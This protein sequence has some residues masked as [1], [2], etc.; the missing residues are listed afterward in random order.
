MRKQLSAWSLTLSCGLSFGEKPETSAFFLKAYRSYITTS[1][2]RSST[3][4]TSTPA[5][6]LLLLLCPLPLFLST[7]LYIRIYTRFY[8]LTSW[9]IAS[10]AASILTRVASTYMLT[11]SLPTKTMTE[12]RRTFYD[13]SF[14]RSTRSLQPKSSQQTP[15]YLMRPQIQGRTPTQAG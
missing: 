13:T 3:F 7:N 15:R 10:P 6:L 12:L 11:P 14:I 4:I 8:I 9:V 2:V 5:A 1:P